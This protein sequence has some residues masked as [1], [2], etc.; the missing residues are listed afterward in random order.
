M[1]IEEW[2]QAVQS[3]EAKLP[4]ERGVEE[5]LEQVWN[6]TRQN[7][8]EIHST[9]AEAAVQTATYMELP[10]KIEIFGDFDGFYQFLL[11]LEQIPR[12]TRIH[13][14]KIEEAA[15]KRRRGGKPG[16]DYP[17]G[18]MIATFTLSI[19]YEPTSAPQ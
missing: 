19:F 17:E 1:A 14:M 2:R 12:I 3:I 10:L 8:L 15:G 18:T 11:E 6:V 9:H 7:G 13:N 16:D 4:T 5:I